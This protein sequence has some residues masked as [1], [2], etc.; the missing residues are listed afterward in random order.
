METIIFQK[1]NENIQRKSP[2]LFENLEKEIR[3]L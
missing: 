3:F 1:K 2:T